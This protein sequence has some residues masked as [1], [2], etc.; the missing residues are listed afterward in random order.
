MVSG[1]GEI[2]EDSQCVWESI[3]EADDDSLKLSSADLAATAADDQLGRIEETIAADAADSCSVS[4]MTTVSQLSSQ[5][6]VEHFPDV[7][8]QSLLKDVICAND[9]LNQTD[10]AT[11]ADCSSVDLPD[12]TRTL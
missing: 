12:V 10:E 6:A 8:I 7:D 3:P 5:F 1:D 2:V 4:R 9:Q 11:T